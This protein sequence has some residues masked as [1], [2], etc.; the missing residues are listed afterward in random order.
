MQTKFQFI[1]IFII[2]SC[3]LIEP[4][5]CIQKFEWLNKKKSDWSKVFLSNM[6]WI[7]FVFPMKQQNITS[8]HN[9]LIIMRIS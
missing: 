1:S 2:D 9:G 7:Q 4:N 5:F 3:Y 6:I 8:F